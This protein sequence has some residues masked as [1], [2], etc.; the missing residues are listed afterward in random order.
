MKYLG[1]LNVELD[2]V[3]C[4]AV[5]ELLKSP[6]MGQFTREGYLSGWRS[7]PTNPDSIQ[8]QASHADTVRTS[9]TQDP[10]LFKR[11]YRYAFT[12]SRP[13]GSRNL[14]MEVAVDIWKL[15]FTPDKG[16][17]K[18]NTKDLHWLDWWLDFYTTTVRRPV[19]KDLWE[20]TGELV[21]KTMEKG[22]D[23]SW[24]SEDGSWPIAIDEFVEWVKQKIPSDGSTGGSAMEVE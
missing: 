12:I 6:T 14:P 5:C 13:E 17:M 15:F 21:G 9:L 4:L 8:K 19:N 7:V 10:A 11:V 22:R 23:L 16:G 24:W 3:A 18:W 1:D 2:E 20:Q